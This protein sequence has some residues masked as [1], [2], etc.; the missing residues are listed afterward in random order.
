MLNL[1]IKKTDKGHE[2]IATRAYRLSIRQRQ[3]LILLD[4]GTSVADLATL[5]GSEVLAYQVAGELLDDGFISV[6]V[7]YDVPMPMFE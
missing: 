7:P 4:A 3:A 6:D 2:E 1:L 5:W